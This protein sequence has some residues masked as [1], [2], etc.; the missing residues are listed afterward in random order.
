MN[1]AAERLPDDLTSAL[2][3]LEEERARPI[4]AEAEAMIAKAEAAGS[5]SCRGIPVIPL[6]LHGE[7][8]YSPDAY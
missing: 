5:K 3:A 8:R 4:T 2:A 6:S 1:D 7:M